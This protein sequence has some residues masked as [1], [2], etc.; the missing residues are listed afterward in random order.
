MHTASGFFFEGGRRRESG[1]I[2]SKK[3]TIDKL[4]TA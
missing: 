2:K 4:K 3:K 1:E